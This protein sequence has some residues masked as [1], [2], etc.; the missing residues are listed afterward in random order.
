MP[1][2]S[3]LLDVAAGS[4]IGTTLGSSYA[5]GN[6]SATIVTAGANTTGIVV[7]SAC[8]GFGR[9]TT[10]T[11]QF[12][13]QIKAGTSVLLEAKGYNPDTANAVALAGVFIPAGTELTVIVGDTSGYYHITYEVL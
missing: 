12:S 13:A 8:V 11:T 9:V 4:G 1:T 2:L 7:S 10:V 3:S 6:T 5:T